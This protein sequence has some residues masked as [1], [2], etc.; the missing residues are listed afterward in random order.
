MTETR[1]RL[2]KFSLLT[3]IACVFVASILLAL[4]LVPR[5]TAVDTSG[6]ETG[7]H[8]RN[9]LIVDLCAF[10]DENG[11]LH[12]RGWPVYFQRYDPKANRLILRKYYENFS[13]GYLLLDVVICCGIVFAFGVVFEWLALAVRNRLR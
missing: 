10:S 1:R 13:L 11:G 5:P 12:R 6:Q 9:N 2:P 3:A 7:F 8:A 4:N